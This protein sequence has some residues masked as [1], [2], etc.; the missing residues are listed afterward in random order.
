ME[1]DHV[2]VQV[3]PDIDHVLKEDEQLSIMDLEKR[4]NK[5]I[6]IIAREHFHIEQYEISS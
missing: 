1:G 5:R 2:Y 3:N 4:L 6:I